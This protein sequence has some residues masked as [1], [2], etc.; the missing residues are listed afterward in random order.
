[1]GGD[2]AS[3]SPKSM[4]GWRK[5]CTRQ[6]VEDVLVGGGTLGSEMRLEIEDGTPV[7]PSCRRIRHDRLDANGPQRLGDFLHL[8]GAAFAVH[9]DPAYRVIGERLPVDARPRLLQRRE[10][11]RVRPVGTGRQDA[12]REQRFEAFD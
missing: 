12:F 10:D 4:C 5:W 8:A 6:E 1:M 2:Y 11:L 3:V 7:L 9:D